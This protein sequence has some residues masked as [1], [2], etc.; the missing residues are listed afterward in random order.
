MADDDGSLDVQDL[1][2]RAQAV[3]EFVQVLPGGQ[4]IQ[5][6]YPS[7]FEWAAIDARCGDDTPTRV[8][9]MVEASVYGWEGVLVRDALPES[10]T[11]DAPLPFGAD[12]LALV[13]DI[14]VDWLLILWEQIRARKTARDLAIEESLKN[15]EAKSGAS[16]SE[17]PAAMH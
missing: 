16:G 14:R 8:R 3:R 17:P 13:L 12:T 7:R 9:A 15:F 4:R 10:K 2:R 5:V 1:Q 6:R 11:G